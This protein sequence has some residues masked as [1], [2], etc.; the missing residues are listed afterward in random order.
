MDLRPVSAA[1]IAATAAELPD[2]QPPTAKVVGKPGT[3][4][5]CY[6]VFAESAETATGGANW[7][8]AKMP[9]K[10]TN[11]SGACVVANAPDTLDAENKVVLTLQPVAGA[12]KYHVLRT[13]VLPA[14]SLKFTANKAPGKDT[15]YYWVQGHNGWRSSPLG[16]PFKVAV[17]RATFDVAMTVV[18]APA[19]AG[20]QQWGHS[21]WVTETPEPPLGRKPQVIA[22]RYT[23]RFGGDAPDSYT[24]LTAGHSAAWGKKSSGYDAYWLAAWGPA[25]EEATPANTRPVGTGRY[26]I[27]ST[28]QLT[29]ED[30]GLIARTA[31]PPMVNETVVKSFD[32]LLAEPQLNRGVHNGLAVN[33]PF[34][35]ESCMGADFYGGFYPLEMTV[36]ASSGGKN[37]Y[38]NQPA[39]YP[40]YKS[41]LGV[42]QFSLISSTE[43]QHCVSNYSLTCNGM[44]DGIAMGLNVDYH[45]GQRDQGDESGEMIRAS[46]NRVLDT[47]SAVLDADA[48]K[49]SRHLSVREVNGS[50]GTGRMLVNLSQA[51]SEGRIDHVVNCDVY[52]AGTHWSKTQLGWFMSLDIENVQAKRSWFR[53][54]GGARA[55]SSATHAL[56]ELAWRYQPGLQPFYLQSGKREKAA[57]AAGAGLYLRRAGTRECP[58]TLYT[59]P[60]AI[61]V[62]PKSLAKAAAEGK[63]LLS[64]GTFFADAW[65]ESGLHV[66][67]LAED[68]N[69]GDK[70]ELA[71]G[72]GQSMTDRF[73]FHSGE[74]GANDHL[75]GL[76]I[77]SYFDNRPANGD[78]VFVTN[79]GLGVRIALPADRQGNGVIVLGEPVD[80]AFIAAPDVPALRCYHSQIPYLQGSKEHNAMELVAPTGEVPLSVSKAG[81]AVSGCIKGCDQT[82]GEVLLSGDGKQKV[83]P[84]TFAKPFSAQPIV[85]LTTNQFA[86]SRLVAVER[87]LYRGVR[88]STESRTAEYHH[89]VDGAG[90]TALADSARAPLP[91]GHV[92]WQHEVIGK[93]RKM[94]R[95][96]FFAGITLCWAMLVVCAGAPAPADEFVGPFPS[97]LNV[98][99][100]FG[101]RGDGKTDD[102]AAL[103]KAL[104]A[105]NPTAG[106]PKVLYFPAGVYRIAKTLNILARML[107]P[108]HGHEHPGRRPG[109]NDH[110]VG[111]RAGREYALFLRMVLPAR[112]SHAGRRRQGGY[113]HL[114]RQTVRHLQ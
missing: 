6:W 37:C 27:A 86:R 102:T 88:R 62:L 91:H 52:G 82:R 60:L 83:F 43:S 39:A 89:L 68:W 7:Y 64:P 9:G 65:N 20:A 56:V 23:D 34:N 93:E 81:V 106:N 112:P 99:T 103:Q 109:D 111:R 24:G 26:L 1:L 95:A 17:D 51:H 110:Q 101:A 55:R 94:F 40:G 38:M 28:E 45:A 35:S 59:N 10:V 73:G 66:E 32:R 79:M 48:P 113:G 72:T 41:T 8:L 5:L 36:N 71:C 33:I 30:T 11:L 63:Y 46:T 87:K 104:D 22:H 76:T 54:D 107:S 15:L 96:L 69:K 84:I 114:L 49:G 44:G 53:G 97:W 108:R 12:V 77:G 92:T 70:L 14:P 42:S 3:R 67:P 105:I 2:P 16:G 90:I 47:G 57:L 21:I 100:D 75:E 18:P 58:D 31:Q 13:E 61:G 74:L 19:Q 98:K 29:V 78:G 80:G 4:T 50:S 25:P 85:L